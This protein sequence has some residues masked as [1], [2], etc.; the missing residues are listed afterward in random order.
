M[1]LIECNESFAKRM[2]E[3]RKYVSYSRDFFQR[4]Y[5][6]CAATIRKW[7]T[8]ANKTYFVNIDILAEY[9]EVYK[10][11]LGIKVAMDWVLYGSGDAPELVE[12]HTI[13]TNQ[14]IDLL[15]TGLPFFFYMDRHMLIQRV[16]PE[17]ANLLSD[18]PLEK[19]EGKTLLD[20]LGNERYNI[21]AP[22]LK[23]ALIGRVQK[24]SFVP[25]D[26]NQPGIIVNCRPGLSDT[27]DIIGIFNFIEKV[28]HYESF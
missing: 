23:E 21:Y 10:K 26:L 19:I 16:N 8:P 25:Y 22:L 3:L 13:L 4:R 11:Y 12:H 18:K 6:I 24:Y 5:G 17:Y 14:S 1:P 2:I 15:L 9:L 20:I 27:E 28:H 7:E